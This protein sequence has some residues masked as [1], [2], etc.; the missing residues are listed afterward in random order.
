MRAVL[1]KQGN[2]DARRNESHGSQTPLILACKNGHT[3]VA[4]ALL[5]AKADPN[6]ADGK[7]KTALNYSEQNGHAALTALLIQMINP[8]SPHSPKKDKDEPTVA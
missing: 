5:D 8:P 3:G 2:V 7:G 6:L 4:S 1:R